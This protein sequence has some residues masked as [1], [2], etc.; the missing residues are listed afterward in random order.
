MTDPRHPKLK[1]A[2]GIVL[3]I[4]IILGL[5]LYNRVATHDELRAKLVATCDKDGACVEAVNRH[6]EGCFE[7]NYSLGGRHRGG[8]V[9]ADGF[10]KCFNARAGQE[11]LAH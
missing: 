6:F 4:G 3:G 7:E 5:K 2:M 10:M 11:H 8:G 1:Q 9:D